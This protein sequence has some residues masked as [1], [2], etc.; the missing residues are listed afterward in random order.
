[1]CIIT[2]KDHKIFSISFMPPSTDEQVKEFIM[3]GY[4]IYPYCNIK[5]NLKE[6][7]YF[8]KDEELLQNLI[9]YYDSRRT[10]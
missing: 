5:E 2:D 8:K 4:N 3:N 1:M 6:G 7:D 9:K 10:Y